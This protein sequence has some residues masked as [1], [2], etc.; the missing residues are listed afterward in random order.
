[1]RK[2][3]AALLFGF[4]ALIA[5]SATARSEEQLPIN[6]VDACEIVLH[7]LVA[8]LTRVQT[9]SKRESTNSRDEDPGVST[10]RLHATEEAFA[11]A[12]RLAQAKYGRCP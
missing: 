5:V 12:I 1:M 11:Q 9:N 7:E 6:E 2:S 4:V 8:D 3:I 10:A